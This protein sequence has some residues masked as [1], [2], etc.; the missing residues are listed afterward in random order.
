MC[1]PAESAHHNKGDDR[2]L[3]GIGGIMVHTGKPKFS[4]LKGNQPQCHF[5]N[6]KSH[7]NRPGT[8]PGPLRWEA[9]D[10]RTEVSIYEHRTAHAAAQLMY[11]TS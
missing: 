10:Q 7:L 6:D 4:N 8:K 3:W 5:V 1:G 2:R 11:C 9:G